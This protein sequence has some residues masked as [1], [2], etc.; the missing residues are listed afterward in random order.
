MRRKNIYPHY[1]R[2]RSPHKRDSPYLRESPVNRRDSPHSRSGSSV[3]SRG[4]SPERSK[5]YAF[6]HSQHNRSVPSLH[7]RNI[8]QQGNIGLVLNM[9]S[10]E[11]TSLYSKYMVLNGEVRKLAT[12]HTWV[13]C[14]LEKSRDHLIPGVKIWNRYGPMCPFRPTHQPVLPSSTILTCYC[15]VCQVMTGVMVATAVAGKEAGSTTLNEPRFAADNPGFI[16]I[17]VQA[18]W[19]A[20]VQTLN[21]R[22]CNTEQQL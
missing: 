21:P 15:M 9:I 16:R 11:L 4:Y 1:A 12:S 2:D 14:L 17:F 8:S 7:K 20:H 3:S 19:A 10:D 6:H 22:S 13:K 18:V 5:A